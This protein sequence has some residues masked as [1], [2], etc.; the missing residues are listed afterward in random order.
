[1]PRPSKSGE[2]A[3]EAC[4]ALCQPQVLIMGQPGALI[5]LTVTFEAGRRPR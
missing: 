5:E 4:L 2:P 3:G 1:M